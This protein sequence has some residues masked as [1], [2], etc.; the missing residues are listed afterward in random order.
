MTGRAQSNNWDRSPP[1]RGIWDTPTWSRAPSFQQERDLAPGGVGRKNSQGEEINPAYNPIR[2]GSFSGGISLIRSGN[3]LR[4][5]SA[6]LPHP[7]HQFASKHFSFNDVEMQRPHL[8]AS[9]I[10]NSPQTHHPIPAGG[11]SFLSRFSNIGDATRDAELNLGSRKASPEDASGFGLVSRRTSTSSASPIWNNTGSPPGQQAKLHIDEVTDQMQGFTPFVPYERYYDYGADMSG[12]AGAGLAGVAPGGLPSSGA[13]LGPASMA[14]GGMSGMGGNIGPMGGLTQSPQAPSAAIANGHDFYG[15]RGRP[16][17]RKYG[18][19]EFFPNGMDDEVDVSKKKGSPEQLVAKPVSVRS[20]N[21]KAGVAAAVAEAD[22]SASAAAVPTATPVPSTPTPPRVES[23]DTNSAASGAPSS[24]SRRKRDGYRSPLLEEFRNNKSK[25]FELKDL[26]G[27]IVE[28][29]GDQHGSRFIQQQLESASGEEKSAI[30]EEIRPSSLQL[31]TDV[32]GNYVVQKFFVHG[33]NAQKAVLTKQMEGHV[34]SLSLQ[35]YGCRVVQKAIEYVDTAKQAHLINELD[36]HVLRC[37]KDQNGNH[38]IQKAIEKI[39]PQHIQFIINAFNEQVYQ[40]ATHPYGC[41]VIQRMLEH[42]EEAQAAILAELHNYA[43]HLIQDQ[44]GNYVIQHVL[45]QGAPD[46]K[47]AMM[48]VIKQHVLIFSRH[49][50]ASNVVEKCVIYGNRR[51]RRALIEEIATEREDG[52][53]PITVM[54]KDQFANYVIQKLLDV[55]EGEDF[56][57]LVSII[58]PHLA[59]LKKYSYGKHLAS[60]E[61]LVLLSEGGE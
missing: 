60:I 13:P 3:E 19:K 22:I 36:K 51:Q 8:Q 12:G 39:P 55:S 17:P 16:S 48:L 44:Y 24:S 20:P 38:V 28:F 32:F 21:N 5:D 33:S 35:M 27:H 58:K 59:S 6:M 1:S 54:M 34:L 56:D 25:K 26:Q 49:K 29:S 40:L 50:F 47:E 2:S 10:F 53:L 52:T 18:V 57:L 7:D 46:D 4:R 42:C 37:V 45:E 31:M 61:R 23:R 41:R 30:F 14:M 9:E 43:F 15:F 11:S